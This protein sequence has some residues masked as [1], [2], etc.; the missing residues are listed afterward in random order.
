MKTETLKFRLTAAEKL[1]IHKA[2][3]KARVHEAKLIR[4]ALFSRF[5]MKSK[6]NVLRAALGK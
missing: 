6:P 1:A 3:V 5:H 4:L 2:S